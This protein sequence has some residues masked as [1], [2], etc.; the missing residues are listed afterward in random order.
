M[1]NFLGLFTV[2]FILQSEDSAV[3]DFCDLS[4][5]QR[6]RALQMEHRRVLP[7]VE[8]LFM[9]STLSAHLKGRRLQATHS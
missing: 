3:N 9:H 6:N 8:V 1:E 2:L 4:S 5:V 7:S